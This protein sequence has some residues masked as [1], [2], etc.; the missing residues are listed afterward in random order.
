MPLT[1]VPSDNHDD[2]LNVASILIRKQA[3][4]LLTLF[5]KGELFIKAHL[6][7]FSLK[8]AWHSHPKARQDQFINVI[9]EF[10]LSSRFRNKRILDREFVNWCLVI[11]SLEKFDK[12]KAT[13]TT[14]GGISD[15]N[16]TFSSNYHGLTH[17]FGASIC[18]DEMMKCT[19]IENTFALSSLNY[20]V[21]SEPNTSRAMEEMTDS[22]IDILSLYDGDVGSEFQFGQ[23]LLYADLLNV[24]LLSHA[25]QLKM[26][27]TP[28]AM[29]HITLSFAK[30]YKNNESTIAYESIL[31]VLKDYYAENTES[32][33]LGLRLSVLFD[34]SVPGI[35]NPSNEFNYHLQNLKC[36]A[37]ISE[38]VT[39]D[40]SSV[41]MQRKLL[42]TSQLSYYVTDNTR[43]ST[44]I[45]L[46]LALRT[47]PEFEML[48]DY[49]YK[50]NN[51]DVARAVQSNKELIQELSDSIALANYLERE[52]DSMPLA[53]EID[54]KQPF[55]MNNAL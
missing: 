8:Y 1:L 45:P 44:S 10:E 5:D 47:L 27:Q 13:L 30:A 25:D 54:Q 14:S 43:N 11:D 4:E 55:I 32:R 39:S 33:C 24:G 31:P 38:L 29:F 42:I 17:T 46:L 7:N 15:R 9:D 52:I 36:I 40:D 37:A 23:T 53:N 16:F 18:Y 26:V 12:Q 3:I 35:G 49:K 21:N 51:C 50:V 20:S 34:E 22:Q 41:N 19:A 6:E 28:D 2:A 48:T